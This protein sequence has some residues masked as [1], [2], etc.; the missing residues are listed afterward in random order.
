MCVTRIEPGAGHETVMAGIF[1][2]PSFLLF[3]GAVPEP[4]PREVRQEAPP[5]AAGISMVRTAEERSNI[6]R[7]LRE[8][9]SARLAKMEGWAEHGGIKACFEKMTPVVEHASIHGD[10]AKVL[11]WNNT[12]IVSQSACT[13]DRSVVGRLFFDFF[14]AYCPGS[15][16]QNIYIE[17]NCND[18]K[19]RGAP[20]TVATLQAAFRSAQH[21]CLFIDNPEALLDGAE[22]VPVHETFVIGAVSTEAGVVEAAPVV[23]S[24][25]HAVQGSRGKVLVLL[26]STAE[27]MYRFMDTDVRLK[28]VIPRTVYLPDR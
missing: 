5:Q 21:G 24:I 23:Q 22:G 15:V 19:G 28:R 11:G 13:S 7:P 4:E 10:M 26:A 2:D 18:L 20:E 3:P 12:R 8:A 14:R 6:Q 16:F 25:L 1:D 17:V 9:F 27:G